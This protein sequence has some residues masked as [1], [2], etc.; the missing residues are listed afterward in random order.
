MSTK[1]NKYVV[2][3]ILEHV[4]DISFREFFGRIGVFL[5]F[6]ICYK[7][8]FVSSLLQYLYLHWSFFFTKHNR[9]NYFNLVFLALRGYHRY[10]SKSTVRVG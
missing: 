6:F 1:H 4:D 7:I 8:M 10:T 5:L 3:Q 9:A 2:N